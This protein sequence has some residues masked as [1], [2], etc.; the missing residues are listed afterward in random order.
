MTCLLAGDSIPVSLKSTSNNDTAFDFKSSDS[1]E[2]TGQHAGPRTNSIT[3]SSV[4]FYRKSD[5]LKLAVVLEFLSK[6]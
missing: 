6:L 1:W 3:I 5:S 2:E 4:A